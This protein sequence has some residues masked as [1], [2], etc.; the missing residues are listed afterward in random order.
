[1]KNTTNSPAD[2]QYDLYEDWIRR[3]I[4]GWAERGIKMTRTAIII[5]CAA[6]CE[7]YLKHDFALEVQQIMDMSDPNTQPH[8]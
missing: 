7:D 8:Q 5:A 6:P 2:L 3:V 1:M 4:A